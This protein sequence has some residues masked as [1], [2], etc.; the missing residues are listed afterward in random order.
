MTKTKLENLYIKGSERKDTRIVALTSREAYIL[1]KLSCESK[2]S[3]DK[4]KGIL[5]DL[6]NKEE[7][8]YFRA[9]YN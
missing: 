7:R 8:R 5:Y 1:W 4:I 3:S 2:L 9:K 6:I